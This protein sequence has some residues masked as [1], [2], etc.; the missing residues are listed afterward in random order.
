METSSGFPIGI[1]VFF[2]LLMW[3]GI[4]PMPITLWLVFSFFFGFIFFAA[5]SLV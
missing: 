3:F 4:I 5:T 2:L 1:I